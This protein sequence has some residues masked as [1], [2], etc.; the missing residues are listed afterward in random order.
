MIPLTVDRAADAG[1]CVG[2]ADGRVVFVRGALPGESVRVEVTDELSRFWRGE[3][4]AV[5]QASPHR[6]EPACPWFRRC[7]GCDWLHADPNEQ[8]RIKADVLH[9]TLAR[10]GGVEVPV[11]VRS[12]GRQTGWR[13]RVTLH[14]DSAGAAGFYAHGSHDVVAVAH[15]LQAAAGMELDEVLAQPWPQAQRVHVSISAAGR[16]LVAG[17][18]RFGPDEHHDDVLGRR[19]HRALDGFWQ[20]HIDAAQTLAGAV[21]EL[22]E[23]AGSVVDLYAGVGLFGLTV[24]DVLPGASV[25]LVEGDRTAAGFARRNAAGAARVLGID[26]RRWRPE[27]ADLVVLDPPRAGAGPKVVAAVAEA[28]PATVIYVSCDP[29]TL[30]RDL[31][32]FGQRGYAPD[33]IEGFDLFPGTAHV[34][35]VVRLRG[36]RS[37]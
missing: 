5:D 32:M 4:V 12:L 15:C 17:P 29:A 24:L 22:V 13:T 26:V 16:S 36:G 10:I 2:R 14:L 31:K 20:V 35:T 25:T 27:P 9:D 1:Q 7:G 8:L 34:E 18:R 3:V 37:A 23:P 33:H 19:F 30:A 21:R 28:S 6:V 11:S